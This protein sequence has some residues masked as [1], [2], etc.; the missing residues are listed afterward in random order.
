[1]SQRQGLAR[2]RAPQLA[3]LFA[4]PMAFACLLVARQAS[5]APTAGWCWVITSSIASVPSK[6]SARGRYLQARA[7]PPSSAATT[8]FAWRPAYR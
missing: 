8:S 4:V 1:M 2:L 6:V 5:A 7:T 3:S